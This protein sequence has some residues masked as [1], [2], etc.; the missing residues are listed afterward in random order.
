[1]TGEPGQ[2][3]RPMPVVLDHV[4]CLIILVHDSYRFSSFLSSSELPEA[5]DNSST[6]ICQ[7]HQSNQLTT[8][9]HSIQ[10]QQVDDQYSYT[11][12]VHFHFCENIA[13]LSVKLSNS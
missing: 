9:L 3:Y 6:G 2:V 8:V 10:V 4:G 11:H 7:C 13:V 12:L 1:M 5:V